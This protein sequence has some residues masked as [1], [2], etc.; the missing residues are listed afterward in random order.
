MYDVIQG[1]I[2]RVFNIPDGK[3]LYALDRGLQK[4]EIYSISFANDNFKKSS[5]L[6]VTSNR[7]TLHI[8]NLNQKR[9]TYKEGG[10]AIKLLFT[11]KFIFV[12]AY[13]NR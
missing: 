5:M 9:Y 7:G 10:E 12:K 1:Q 3:K 4:A 8:F 6:A 13:S 11:S 2:I